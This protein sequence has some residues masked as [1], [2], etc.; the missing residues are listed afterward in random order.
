MRRFVLSCLFA[1]GCGSLDRTPNL[2]DVTE[3]SPR[4]LEVGDRVR[5]SGSGFPEGRPATVTL[6]GE[7]Y[8]AG[9]APQKGLRIVTDAQIVAPHAIEA[10]ITPELAGKLC[11]AVDAR[12]TTFRGDVEVSFA[13]KSG[14]GVEVLGRL[15]GVSIDVVPSFR[16]DQ[17]LY[18]A[19]ADGARFARFLGISLGPSPDGLQVTQVEPKSRA[20]RAGLLAS[21]VV[22]EVDGVVVRGP[23]DFIPPP[24]SKN[25]EFVLRRGPD[26][27]VLRVDSSGFRYSSPDTLRPAI[28][29]I[30]LVLGL[31]LFLLS[32]LGRWL[33]V[34]ERSLSERLRGTSRA[35]SGSAKTFHP[36]RALGALLSSELPESF[37]SYLALVAGSAL[38]CLLSLGR[39]VIAA[40]LD[41]AVVPAATLSGL[42][43]TA[44]LTRGRDQTW[45]PKGALGRALWVLLF[46]TPLAA[47]LIVTALAAGSLR[48]TDIVGLQGAW[49][50][51]W[52][53]FKD[54]AI[55]CVAVLVLLS[56]VPV[57]ERARP[58]AG[59]R[60]RG[61]LALAEWIHSLAIAALLS[62]LAFGG[63]AVPGAGTSAL[64]IG[65]GLALAL[66]K[67]WLVLLAVAALR[68]CVGSVDMA[69]MKRPALLGLALPSGLA[70]I[71]ELFLDR[72]AAGPVVGTL[73]AALPAAALA[74]VTLA[75]AF[76][77]WRVVR[78]VRAPNHE[79]R[80]QSWL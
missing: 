20:A 80:V 7:L 19:R 37:L 71:A 70:V 61:S 13:P 56:M 18:A 30:G 72:F 42:V 39:S 52:A 78:G 14:A 32:P 50:W 62:L 21:D 27:L 66:A 25:S 8:R 67:S 48:P 59:S 45:S 33:G 47:F 44:L 46:N 12:H 43:V 5:V 1:L 77:I 69:S 6:R 28:F 49:P 60:R 74:S 34:L 3:I 4:H 26:S 29:V 38:V 58:F 40:E 63:Y 79:L 36:G 15:D 41:V 53:A 31:C 10:L 2:I 51:Q 17:A 11:G 55:G 75:S 68:W 65:L 57:L 35:R 76:L 9:E 54:P 16:G 64:S 24:N 73:V 23:S 22:Q